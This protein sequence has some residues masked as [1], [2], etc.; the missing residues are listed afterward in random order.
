M[1]S[2][3]VGMAISPDGRYLYVTSRIDTGDPSPQGNICSGYPPGTLSV[4]DI[5]RAEQ[6]ATN[7]VLTH[8]F[9]GY[10]PVQVILSASGDTAWVTVQETNM[11][12]AFNTRLLL[13]N[14]RSALLASLSV[15]Q[16]PTSI[17]LVKN[18]SVLVIASSNRFAAPQTPQTLTLLDAKQALLGH[19][20]ILG[21]VR[22]GA[23]PRELTLEAG[24][25]ILLLTNFLS[26]T[27]EI[28]D[29]ASLP[30]PLQF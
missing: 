27:L 24:G 9:A 20:A 2:G 6:G 4:I 13:T 29:V 19:P 10:G 16:A 22:T 21:T 7:A 26:D 3:L 11:L 23:F 15:G 8:V 1:D 12:L 25:Q 17:A 14:P 30:G 18:G 5:G 28:I